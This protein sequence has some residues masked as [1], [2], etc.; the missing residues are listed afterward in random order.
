MQKCSKSVFLPGE[1]FDPDSMPNLPDD[2]FPDMQEVKIKTETL[3]QIFTGIDIIPKP[4]AV[5][6]SIPCYI[7]H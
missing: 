1:N 6:K 5:L 3:E 7:V 4:S 2:M